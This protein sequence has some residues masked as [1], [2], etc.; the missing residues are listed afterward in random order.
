[1]IM[2]CLKNGGEWQVPLGSHLTALLHV[3]LRGSISF[4][5]KDQPASQVVHG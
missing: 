3:I 5:V 2:E 4:L 1:M